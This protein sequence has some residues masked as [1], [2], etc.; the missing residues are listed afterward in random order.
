MDF[1]VERPAPIGYAEGMETAILPPVDEMWDAFE[2]RDP[3]YDGIFF[4][5]V[6]TT[7]IFCRPT[8]TAKKPAR[9]NVEFYSGARDA[10]TAGYRPCK[11][12]RPMKN[13]AAPE[14]IAGL[15]KAV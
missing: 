12:C 4:T 13:G 3:E 15:L 9:A 14:W 5:A 6:T 11:R 2:R 10:L 7:G 8:C 1:P